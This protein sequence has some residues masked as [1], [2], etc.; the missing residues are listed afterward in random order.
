LPPDVQERAKQAYRLWHE[1]PHLTGLRFKQV[2]G[3][4]SV[5]LAFCKEIRFTGT[6]SVNTMTM[7]G[8]SPDPALPDGKT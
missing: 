6:G 5:R 3:E 2:A 4:V 8:S 1:N 7:T